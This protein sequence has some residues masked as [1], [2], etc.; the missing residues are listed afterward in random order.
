VKP[1]KPSKKSA[2]MKTEARSSG[3]SADEESS[4]PKVPAGPSSATKAGAR[5]IPPA[6]AKGGESGYVLVTF[7]DS[8][9]AS[10]EEFM[11]LECRRWHT[12][13]SAS[14]TAEMAPLGTSSAPV[15]EG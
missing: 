6:S 2:A 9:S 10:E 12:S 11:P 14:P 1:L 5:K 4:A 8:S 3:L 15:I 7:I 13:A